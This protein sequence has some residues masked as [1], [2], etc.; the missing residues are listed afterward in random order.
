MISAETVKELRKREIPYIL[1]TRMRK[2]NEVKCDVLYSAQEPDWKQ[3][4][5]D[6]SQD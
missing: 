5:S 6:V 3:G 2:V 4:I 1:G